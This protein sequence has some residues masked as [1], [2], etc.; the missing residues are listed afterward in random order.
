[1]TAQQPGD[2]K[3]LFLAGKGR[4]GGTLLASL[5]GQLPGLLQHRR[6]EPV[7][8]LGPRLELPCGCGLPVQ[9]C[10]T[11]HAILDQRRP[12]AR[13]HAGSRRSATARIDLAQAS[14]VRWPRMAAA[15]A[16]REPGEQASWEALDRYTA[17]SSAVYR[18]IAHVTGARVVVDSSRLPIEP[19]ALGLVPGVDVRVA[20]VIRDPRAVVY[21]WK[22]SKITTDRDTGEY[23]PKFERVVLHHEL[24]R[25]Q[26]RRRGDRSPRVRSRS[27]STTTMARDPGGR[28]APARRVRRRTGRR[29]GVPHVGDRDDRADALGRRQPDAHDER[30]DHD[31]ARRGVAHARSRRATASSPPRSRCRCSTATACPFAASGTAAT[32]RRPRDRR[33]S[34]T[35]PSAGCRHSPPMRGCAS[36]RSARPCASRNR[37][38][39]SRSAPAKA[40]LGA[41]LAASLHLHR[42]RA[43]RP[44]ACGRRSAD[45][46]RRPRH[47]RRAARRCRRSRLRPRVRV[48]SA[49]AHRRRR[50][51]RSK[52]WRE[53]LRPSGWLL[54]SVPAHQDHY[55]AADE[56]V[57]HYRRYERDTLTVRGSRTPASKSCGSAATAPGFGHVLQT[58]PQRAGRARARADGRGRRHAR[59]T[60]VGQRAAVPAATGRD[61]GRVRDG[62][63]A[64]SP[65]AGAVR[66]AAISAPATSCSRAAPSD[67]AVTQ[68]ARAPRAAGA[69]DR[70]V[71]SRHA[72]RPAVVPAPRPAR[73]R[74]RGE[75]RRLV[76]G[77]PRVRRPRARR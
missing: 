10:P 43:R 21:S 15:A 63:R 26:P 38:P 50:R 7:V 47:D 65:G 36:T 61:R 70:H 46:R 51:R 19:V 64:G 9:E 44:V 42:C 60:H 12:A 48:R 31:R 58:G 6:A 69:R 56:L 17:A 55:G 29:H 73:L 3:V 27:C 67:R 11:W 16:R 8:G 20:Q 74:R 39:C 45:R 41:W 5:L 32:P 54:L 2:V 49:R 66:R 24:A 35:R 76:G 68:P 34:T 22:R 1:M 53:Y 4:S 13:R 33:R 18:S 71:R 77:R 23:M 59:G 52:Q 62:R 25:A 72:P 28:A 75:E 14:V 40:A 30:R 37:P 57:G